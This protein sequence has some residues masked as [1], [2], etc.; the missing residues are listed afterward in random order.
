MKRMTAMVPAVAACVLVAALAMMGEAAAQGG[1]SGTR[2]TID[3]F[4][5][6]GAP[7]VV[8]GTVQMLVE[9]DFHSGRSTHHHFLEDA[10]TGTR[11]KL[12]IKPQ[13]AGRLE[14]GMKVRV[15]G[16]LAGDELTADD[17][18]FGVT[19]LKNA[20]AMASPLGARKVLILLVDIVDAAGVKHSI[21]ASC[22]GGTDRAAAETFGFNSAGANVDACYQDSSFGRLGFGGT[23]Y[24]GTE[25][26]V[27]RVT[28]TDTLACNY[29][30][31]GS[32]ADAKAVN[33]S[34]YTHRV[35]VV[36]SNVDCGWAGLAYIN[37]C[38]GALCQA[39]V[40]A[41]SS[42]PC[43]YP[44]AIAHEIG[45]NLGLMH[46][47]TDTDNN[48]TLDCE[49]CDD[50]DFMGY[51][52]GIHRPLNGPHRVQMGW[53]SGSGIIDASAGGQFTLAPLN[54]QSPAYAQVARIVRPNGDPYYISFRDDSG[55]D[56][57][58]AYTHWSPNLVGEISIHR[59]PGGTTNTRFIRSL[60][61]GESFTDAANSLT[62][63]QNGQS[64]AGVTFTVMVG[65]T[66]PA[67]VKATAGNAQVSVTWN[68]TAGAT[69][70]NVKRAGTSGGPYSTIASNVSGTSHVDTAVVNGQTYYYVVSS[71]NGASES[72]N[73]APASA[74]PMGI[75]LVTAAVTNP[76]AQAG[77]G[78]SFSASDAVKNQGGGTAAASTT[79]YYLSA[80]TV[81]AT[82]DILFAATRAVPS[83][84]AGQTASGG[85][86]LTIPAATPLGAYYLLACA[87]DPNAL[88]ETN[89]TNNCL[90]SATTLQIGLSDLTIS[91]MGNPP[92]AATPGGTFALS[93]TVKNQGAMTAAASTL[94]FYLSADSAKDAG[95]VLLGGTR[96]VASLASGLTSS[97]NTTLTI[98]ASVATG[99]YHVLACADDL[100]A[101]G[102][103]NENNNCLASAAKVQI[104]LPD[105]VVTALANPPA[106]I[107]RGS[108]LSITATVAN[109]GVATAAASTVRYY[110]SLD[111]Q[112][113]GADLLL[114]TTKSVSSLS[115][116]QSTGAN[117]KSKVP[118][119][120]ALGTYY[121][122]ACADDLA[123][124]AEL[125]ESNNCRVSATTVIV[126]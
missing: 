17:S 61:D 71:L 89:E 50:S 95:D 115:A 94:R 5:P 21:A 110:L 45:H 9:D 123:V 27:Q 119:N 104:S 101:V 7:V 100:N 105:L 14:P 90:A 77:P 40:K 121:L 103:S 56:A 25:L 8:E 28:I 39:W 4:A 15:S 6:T 18:A 120:A 53:V 1:A 26:D 66:S 55:Y 99:A 75:D 64:A 102:E 114:S 47:S 126:R 44:D 42:Q 2:V 83:L 98:P 106:T 36:P 65:A 51:A 118:A 46:S 72:P 81:R 108:Q 124:V 116:G 59:W 87:D 43:G 109:L 58:L 63:V 41:Y 19:M 80:G 10:A 88:G 11:L 34:S 86:T 92:A 74:T 125:D 62:I 84:S 97:G 113:N 112:K 12:K 117:V 78:A 23:T 30:S 49:Y 33:L 31:W 60:A 16:N 69:G 96:A 13:H 67:N 85:V 57:F 38:P 20:V 68:A 24:P 76:P 70:Y 54:Q 79:R 29:N 122:L 35:Y 32:K 48:G 91:V 37:A 107:A 93:A 73:S 3:Q 52:E 22:D 82:G 111:P